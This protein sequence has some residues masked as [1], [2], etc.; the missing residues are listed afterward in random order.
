MHYLKS[1][2]HSFDPTGKGVQVQPQ[3]GDGEVAGLDSFFRKLFCLLGS[4]AD[5]VDQLYVCSAE[6]TE[7]MCSRLEELRQKLIETGQ[8]NLERARYKGD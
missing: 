3:G 5:D 1:C 7:E 8:T 4:T 2:C 6:K